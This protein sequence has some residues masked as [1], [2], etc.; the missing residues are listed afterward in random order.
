MK[1]N[2]T[3]VTSS[4]ML[5]VSTSAVERRETAMAEPATGLFSMMPSNETRP[6]REGLEGKKRERWGE[7]RGRIEAERNAI[8]AAFMEGF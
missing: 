8:S 4:A 1:L 5:T 2:V 3:W 7:E 6:E